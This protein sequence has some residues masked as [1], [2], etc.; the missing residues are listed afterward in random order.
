M[1]PAPQSSDELYYSGSGNSTERSH[2]GRWIALGA[3]TTLGAI[4]IILF[5]VALILASS[6]TLVSSNFN[7]GKGPFAAESDPHVTLQY[8]LGKGLSTFFGTT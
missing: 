5:V 7:S 6:N 8:A 4:V 2:R 1:V 3:N